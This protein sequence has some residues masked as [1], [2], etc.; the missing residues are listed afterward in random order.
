MSRRES[1]ASLGARQNDALFEFENFKKKFLLANKHITKL[2]STLSVRIEELNAQ[3]SMLYVENLRLR[4]SEIAL[5]GQLKR[6][7]EK[8]R[9]ILA[10]AETASQNLI[11]QLSYL[12]ESFGIKAADETPPTPPSPRARR[13]ILT[14]PTSPQF[15]RVS[16]PPNIPGIIEDDEPGASSADEQRKLTTPPRRKSKSKPR[17]STSKLPLPTRSGSPSTMNSLPAGEADAAPKVRKQI[18]R[19]SGLLTVNTE[20]LSVPRSG[21]PAFG[22]PIR[23]QAG[24]AEEAEEIAAVNGEFDVEMIEQE[25]EADVGR[26]EKRKGKT[27][28]PEEAKATKSKIKEGSVP[29]SALQ[30]IDSNANDRADADKTSPAR[31]FLRPISPPRSSSPTQAASSETDGAISGR[32]RRVRKSVNYAEPKLNTKMRKP[33]PP[34]GSEPTRKKRASA[35]AVMTTSSYKPS[36][37]LDGAD[38]GVE[39]E[40]RSSLEATSSVLPLKGASGN[41][42]NP[43]LFPIPASRP[44]S[45]AALYSPGPPSKPSASTAASVVSTSTAA[46]SSSNTAVKRK[47]SRPLFSDEDSDGAEAD[48]EFINGG[49]L[50]STGWVNADGRRK[51]LPKRSAATAAVAAIEDIRRHSMVM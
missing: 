12:R 33:D 19:Q 24:R 4:A 38:E 32:E 5:A 35:A 27:R 31:Q 25:A 29:R 50:S 11:K 47:K 49:R 44:G 9:K 21:S 2:N 6:E 45:A 30:P 16:R 51:A 48:E 42:I 8:S 37:V 41:Y 10:D 22:S 15:P 20:A 18:R 1:R 36:V 23:L 39:S 28:E 43:E 26:K 17:S 7:R 46:S 14:S 40:P 13:P 34:P 3:I